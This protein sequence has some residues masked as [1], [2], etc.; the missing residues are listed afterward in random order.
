MGDRDSVIGPVLPATSLSLYEDMLAVGAPFESSSNTGVNGDQAN[1]D[2][3]WAGAVYVFGRTA[4]VWPQQAY[5]KALNTEPD[6]LFGTSVAVLPDLLVVGAPGQDS[7]GLGPG[8][9]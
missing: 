3:H 6:N 2:A 9:D 7:G 1:S 4:G 5:V 8:S